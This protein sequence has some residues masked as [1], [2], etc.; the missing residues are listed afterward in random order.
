MSAITWP[1]I[2]AVSV[3]MEMNRAINIARFW[4]G[5]EEAACSLQMYKSRGSATTCAILSDDRYVLFTLEFLYRSKFSEGTCVV[6][7]RKNIQGGIRQKL[8][9]GDFIRIPARTPAPDTARWLAGI[10][11]LC[12]QGEGLSALGTRNRCFESL[13]GTFSM[14][15][16][17]HC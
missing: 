11:F 8:F 12:D 9:A 5:F 6:R 4:N 15:S 7:R 3:G 10:H 1:R 2:M 13:I 14:R 16:C 17:A